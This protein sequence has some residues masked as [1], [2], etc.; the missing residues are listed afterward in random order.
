MWNLKKKSNSWET[1]EWWLSGVAGRENE[2]LFVKEYK[3]SAVRGISSEEFNI[4]H[5]DCEIVSYYIRALSVAQWVRNPTCRS[6]RVQSLGQE[7]LLE[8]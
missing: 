4:R 6:H 2:K 1:G 7:A 5:G 3:P 8:E